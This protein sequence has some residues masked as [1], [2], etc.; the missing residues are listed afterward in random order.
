VH[1]GVPFC[2]VGKGGGV[3]RSGAMFGAKRVRP[4]APTTPYAERSSP[5]CSASAGGRPRLRQVLRSYQGIPLQGN[6][7]LLAA[8]KVLLWLLKCRALESLTQV[9]RRRIVPRSGT[10]R[11]ARRRR[12]FRQQWD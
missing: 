3:R 5:C 9:C 7:S 2:A 10:A 6:G 8:V 12:S 1:T 11:R 4:A